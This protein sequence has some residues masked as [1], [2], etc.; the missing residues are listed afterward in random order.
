MTPFLIGHGIIQTLKLPALSHSLG[1]KRWKDWKSVSQMVPMML[2]GVLYISLSPAK[3]SDTDV[4]PL[5]NMLQVAIEQ[6]CIY[7][8]LIPQN[9]ALP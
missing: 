5:A 1:P 3:L 9:V 4:H 6:K 2:W 8:S 7:R